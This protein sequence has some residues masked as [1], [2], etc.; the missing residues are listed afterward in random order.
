VD[1]LDYCTGHVEHVGTLYEDILGDEPGIKECCC[2]VTILFTPSIKLRY[3]QIVR[4]NADGLTGFGT[5]RIVSDYS[6]FPASWK[7]GRGWDRPQ[8]SLQPGAD[9]KVVHD[10]KSHFS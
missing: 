3:N 1:S 9:V 2:K 4:V 10:S 7:L 5:G 6:I 8:S